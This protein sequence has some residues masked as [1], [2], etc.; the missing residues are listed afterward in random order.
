MLNRWTSISLI[1]QRPARSHG[2]VSQSHFAQQHPIRMMNDS[3]WW[4]INA[5][6]ATDIRLFEAADWTKNFDEWAASDDPLCAATQ[7]QLINMDTNSIFGID[8]AAGY[9][10]AHDSHSASSSIRKLASWFIWMCLQYFGKFL[11]APA[12]VA[13]ECSSRQIHFLV[14]DQKWHDRLHPYQRNFGLLNLWYLSLSH[15]HHGLSTVM[16]RQFT[17]QQNQPKRR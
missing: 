13:T 9:C 3:S 10:G 1:G 5:I 11:I 14:R 17:G 16:P 4:R 15:C 8:I 12:A 7:V 2:K 6:V